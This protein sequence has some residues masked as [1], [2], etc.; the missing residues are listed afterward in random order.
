MPVCKL[1]SISENI[2]HAK[3]AVRIAAGMISDLVIFIFLHSKARAEAG[4]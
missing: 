3:K 1:I 4:C 2:T